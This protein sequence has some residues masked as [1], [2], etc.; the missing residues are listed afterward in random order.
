MNWHEIVND[1]F[2]GKPI[3]ISYCPLC[4]T[5]MAF[6]PG[7]SEGFGVSGLLYN[8]DMLLYDRQ[9]ESLWSQIMETAISG[10][11]KGEKLP[12]VAVQM[13]TWKDWQQRYPESEL[14]SRETGHRRNY[15]ETPYLGYEKS[16]LLY[17]PTSH[18]DDRYHKKEN[19]LGLSIEGKH[20]VWPISELKKVQHPMVDSIG[21][22]KV[23][24][25]YNEA[26]DHAW[27]TDEQQKILPAVRG[28]WF[29]WIAFYPESEVFVGQK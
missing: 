10:P 5:G 24:V 6:E 20:K 11:R 3:V 4:G 15:D 1:D 19:V 16:S 13:T 12:A 23:I 7:T 14:L 18:S 27:I 17:F 8:S 29:A 26:Q 25:N 21:S 2:D 28:Y 22:M 9:T